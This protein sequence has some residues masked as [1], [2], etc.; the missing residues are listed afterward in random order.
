MSHF[1]TIETQI[2]DMRA[3]NDACA[4]LGL[5]LQQN[6]EARGYATNR[7]HGDYTEDI[8]LSRLG[9]LRV[10]RAT[11]IEFNE[12]HQSWQVRTPRG[13]LLF[14][15]PTRLRCLDWEQAYFTCGNGVP[16]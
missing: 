5:E 12:E 10:R 9:R 15:A 8:D 11:R 3:L 14:S 7:R 4:E 1:T 6:A 13:R 2:R 16:A